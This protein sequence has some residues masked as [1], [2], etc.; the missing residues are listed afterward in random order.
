[1]R[2]APLTLGLVALACLATALPSSALVAEGAA[3][4]RGELWRLFTGPLV[5]ANATHLVWDTALLVALGLVF[6]QRF[7]RAWALAL[8]LG[9]AVP[10]AA[11][12]LAHDVRVYYGISGATYALLALVVLTERGPIARV[13]AV[14][15][16]AKLAWSVLHAPLFTPAAVR[17]L[18]IAH[19]AGALAGVL[20]AT[21]T[22][23]QVTGDR[24]PAAGNG[25]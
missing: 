16:A 1:M 7:R 20:A 25:G 15:L 2:R 6:E 23:K 9:L 24:Q 3:L 17:E 14:A 4:A 10:T 8:A 22:L 13:L 18:P 21:R 5:H 11:V 19:V 12:F